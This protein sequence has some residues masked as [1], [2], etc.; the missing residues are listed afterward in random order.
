MHCPYL[1]HSAI[2]LVNI[3][4][5]PSQD[6]CTRTDCRNCPYADDCYTVP[7]AELLFQEKFEALELCSDY[8]VLHF[9]VQDILQLHD[10]NLFVLII[11]QLFHTLSI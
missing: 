9:F 6:G 3:R 10:P 4:L 7:L 8:L 11:I 1:S 5:S 2:V